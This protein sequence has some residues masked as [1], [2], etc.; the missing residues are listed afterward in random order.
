M[1]LVSSLFLPHGPIVFD[2][3]DCSST[4]A[5]QRLSVMP[6]TIREDCQ[7]LYRG[8]CAAVELAKA[9][10]P[11][12]IFLN[13]PHG[14]CLSSR[15]CVYLN[16]KA[17]GNAEWE[18]QWTEYEACVE[19]DLELSRAFL[20]HL[21]KEGVA[22]EGMQVQTSSNLEASLCWSEVLPLWFLSDLTSAGVKVVIFSNPLS[23]HK[24]S[25]GFKEIASV[26]SSVGRFLNSLKE[27]VLYIA[28]GDLSHTHTTD[29]SVPLYCPDPKWNLP[30]S[31]K[32]LPHD[33]CVENWLKCAP[34]TQD[35]IGSIKLT[36]VHSTTLDEETIEDAELWLSRANDMK[37]SSLSCGIY[38]LCLLHGMLSDD[39]RTQHT[40]YTA[41]C[42]CRL[43]PSYFG[44]A[45]AAYIKK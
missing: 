25:P 40:S 20:E 30:V 22:A 29:C 45:V 27:R 11:D 41:H 1:P 36:E 32:A 4:T 26:G 9:S 17:R 42:C 8:A 2:G 21:H 28:S 6:E 16:K 10:K 19:V 39:V 5:N 24:P 43:A 14:V 23:R 13:T 12:V 34:Y 44:M 31:E 7:T 3:A 15:H 18:G 38:G 35:I 33:I 37:M